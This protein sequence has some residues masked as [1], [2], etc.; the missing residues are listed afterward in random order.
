MAIYV[1][2]RFARFARRNRLGKQDLRT[3]ARDVV[4]GHVDADL[5]GGVLKQRIARRGGGKSGGF[6]VLVL[7]KRG[8]NLFYVDGFAK[9]VRGN[10]DAVDLAA[11]RWL[12]D[13]YLDAS[14]ASLCGWVER[15][16]LEIIDGH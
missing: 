5:G 3:L 11:L 8:S 1:T 16:E 10:I 12:A 14:A 2:R 9:N 15:G 7:F 4:A 13:Q 6:R